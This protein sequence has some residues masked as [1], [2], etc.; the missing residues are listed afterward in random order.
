MTAN[1]NFP[2]NQQPLSATPPATQPEVALGSASPA[3]LSPTRLSLTE[4]RLHLPGTPEALPSIRSAVVEAAEMCG[5]SEEDVAKIEMAVGEAC[6]NIIE[7]AYRTQPLKLE[8]EV[9]IHVLDDR[10]EVTI[11]D[12]STINFPIDDSPGMTIDE[13]IETER[14]RGLGLFIIRSFVDGVEHKFICGQGNELKLIKFL[15]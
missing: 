13:Y 7:H 9:Q 3:S 8:I 2:P 6:T 14:R 11:L 1:S 12:Y 4:V 5:F 10:L 15:A